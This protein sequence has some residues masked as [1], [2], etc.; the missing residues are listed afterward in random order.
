M[1]RHFPLFCA[2]ALLLSLCTV[3][4]VPFAQHDQYRYF[5]LPA[6]LKTTCEYDTQFTGLFYDLG[7]PLAALVECAIFK[8][9]HELSDLT[10]ART[11]AIALALLLFS[12]LYAVFKRD[13]F[14]SREKAAAAA[15]LICLVPGVLNLVVMS[16][17]P[18][19]LG[20]SLAALAYFLLAFGW[21]WMPMGIVAMLLAL[22]SYPPSAFIFLSLSLACALTVG[23]D[24]R[25]VFSIIF[26]RFSFC[27]TA[28]AIFWLAV[29]LILHPQVNYSQ[30]PGGP[31]SF[32]LTND[33]IGR[34]FYFEDISLRVLNL[35]NIYESTAVAMGVSLL[36]VALVIWTFLRQAGNRRLLLEKVGIALLGCFLVPAPILL[37]S[38]P[39]VL[40]RTL[41]AYSAFLILL[42]FWLFNTPPRWMLATVVAVAALNGS[43]NLWM[44]ARNSQLE[45]SFLTEQIKSRGLINSRVILVRNVERDSAGKSFVGLPPVGD[46][47]NVNSTVYSAEELTFI[48]RLPM[49]AAGAPA[50]VRLLP[51]PNPSMCKK[52]LEEVRGYPEIV[53]LARVNEPAQWPADWPLIDLTPFTR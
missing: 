10:W 7:R 31:Y 14:W 24:R 34:T 44:N 9:A 26:R 50:N 35:W 17:L 3:L 39:E 19:L 18:G 45:F 23:R 43:F 21:K 12:L 32:A 27:A 16:N 42:L 28:V 37:S 4:T 30:G 22:F 49:V 1:W 53:L 52:A 33:F 25:E 29:K 13:F 15:A 11:L 38:M 48:L 41:V 40:S 8:N 2:G 20:L 36:F 46:E 5:R 6:E 51:C 47:F